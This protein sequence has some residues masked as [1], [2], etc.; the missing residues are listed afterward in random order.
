MRFI[1]QPD[2]GLPNFLKNLRPAASHRHQVSYCRSGI[3]IRCR[4]ER[5][6]NGF[7]RIL[8]DHRLRFARNGYARSNGNLIHDHGASVRIGGTVQSCAIHC[9]KVAF[10]DQPIATRFEGRT[11]FDRASIRTRP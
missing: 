7:S 9:E 4:L 10:A 8:F 11:V 6:D 5:L 3:G 2:V 1:R